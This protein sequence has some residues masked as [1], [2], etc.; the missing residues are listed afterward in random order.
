MVTTGR[1]ILIDQHG[2]ALTY[3]RVSVTD[4]CNLRCQYC[5][6][7]ETFSPLRQDSVLSYEEILRI[8]GTLA[9][10]GIRKIRITGGEPLVRRDVIGLIQRIARLEGI[11]EVGLTTNGVL[12]EEYAGDLYN[13]GIRRLNI[14]LDS[15][16]PERFAEITGKDL[17]SRVWKG[18]ESSLEKGFPYLKLNSVIIRGL[19]D[20]EI[21]SLAR[22]CLEY[23]VQVRFIEY[24]PV[25]NHSLWRPERFLPCE[26]IRKRV[27]AALGALVPVPRSIHDGPAMLFRPGNARGSVGF[28]S[29]LTHHFCA[30]CNRLRLTADGRLRLCLFSDEEIQVKGPLRR[31]IDREGLK[32]LFRK[33]ALRKP[34]GYM[35]PGVAV[36]RCDRP[37]LSIGG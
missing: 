29:P 10:L 22:L 25:G 16:I 15:L 20:D 27:E 33:A 12:L 37:M 34:K 26:D 3:L 13:A 35:S 21:P 17:F 1:E 28:I 23:P 30:T 4:R 24:M 2:R 6:P 8:C 5:S 7:Q 18:F 9:E 19:N 32:E 14:S 11:E 36:P 31:G